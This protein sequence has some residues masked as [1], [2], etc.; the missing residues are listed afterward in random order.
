MDSDPHKKYKQTKIYQ[1]SIYHTI[2]L[3]NKRV[4]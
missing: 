4:L 1:M 2:L 3:G